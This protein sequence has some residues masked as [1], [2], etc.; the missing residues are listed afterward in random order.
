MKKKLIII[1][2]I[3]ICFMIFSINI[4]LA[5]EEIEESAPVSVETIHTEPEIVSEIVA[6]P[7]SVI[8]TVPTPEV[9]TDTELTTVEVVETIPETVV[10][11]ESIVVDETAV[12]AD[13]ETSP[14]ETE[15]ET[16]GVI[17]EVVE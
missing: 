12:T 7:V 16:L 9:I 3:A 17:T 8:E 4:S 1:T 15:P 11:I 5:T 2:L 10:G 6:E 14:E 13:I